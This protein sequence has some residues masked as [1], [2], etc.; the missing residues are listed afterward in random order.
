MTP[1]SELI[2]QWREEPV[3][4]LALQLAGRADIDVPFVLRQVEGWQRLRTKVPS[5]AAIDELEYPHRLALEQCSGEQAARYKAQVVSQLLQSMGHSDSM[6]DLTGGLGVDFS[7]VSP[8]F[9]RSV[10]VE[11]Q[12]SLCQTA[13]HNFPLLG[14]NQVEIV[15]GDG[16]DYLRRMQPVDLIFLDPARRDSAG[17]KTVL[18]EDCEPDVCQMQ[19]LLLEKAETVVLKLS[20]MLDIAGAIHALRCVSDVHVVSVCGECK[21]LLVVMRRGWHSAPLMHA[22]EGSTALCFTLEEEAAAPCEWAEQVEHYLYEPGPAVLK[23]G[24]FRLAGHRYAL[25]KLHPNSHLYTSDQ[26]HEDFPGRIFEVKSTYGFGKRELKELKNQVQQANLTVRNFPS[27]VD[28]LRKK[29]K[30]REGGTVY[31]FATTMSHEQHLLIMCTKPQ[32]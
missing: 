30:L 27:S 26:L 5:W 22:V 17:H 16:V 25:R 6:V 3:E 4:R 24:A 29:L 2:L 1:Q 8:M 13:R 15:C 7:F 10:Y 19:D 32:P 20:T 9:Q 11:R 23:S 28:V 14:L 31:L 21:D 12:E 18:I